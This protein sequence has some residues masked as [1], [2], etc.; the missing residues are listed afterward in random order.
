M[1]EANG[2]A[3]NK[4]RRVQ[5]HGRRMAGLSRKRERARFPWQRSDEGDGRQSFASRARSAWAALMM[6]T[7][8]VLR[9]LP[10]LKGPVTPRRAAGAPC[11]AAARLPGAIRPGT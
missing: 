1:A 4:T 6:V 9:G 2:P 5:R 11:R 10:G 3:A 7:L 8:A